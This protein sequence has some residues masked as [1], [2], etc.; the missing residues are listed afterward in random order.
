LEEH[1]VLGDDRILLVELVLHFFDLLLHGF[2]LLY[3]LYELGLDEI[4]LLLDF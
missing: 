1:L 3:F 2:D 4:V